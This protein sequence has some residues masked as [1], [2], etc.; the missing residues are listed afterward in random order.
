MKLSV[1][2]DFRKIQEKKGMNSKTSR[3]KFNQGFKPSEYLLSG[4]LC[5]EEM[6]I[7]F[8]LRTMTVNVKNNS[9]S[10][11]K[12]DMWCQTC[13]LYTET[14]CNAIR[15]KMDSEHFIGLKYERIFGTLKDQEKFTKV[16]HLMLKA[17]DDVMK[18]PPSSDEG[19]L[20]L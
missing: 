18:I 3:L 20:H 2:D 12:D 5:A 13:F 6:Q 8:K 15:S 11:F 16:Y 14:Q 4:N 10:S 17:R 7:L 19:P 1:R 9:K